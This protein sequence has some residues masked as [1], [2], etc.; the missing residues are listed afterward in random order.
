M[1]RLPSRSVPGFS[2]LAGFLWTA[3]LRLEF[4]KNLEEVF[5]VRL[6]CYVVDVLVSD[7]AFLI[8]DEKSA[9]RDSV[10][11]TIRAVGSRDFAF[12]MK[13]AQEIIRKI[14]EALSP[15]GVARDAVNRDAQD[16]GIVAFEAFEISFIGRHLCRSDRR[17]RQRVER[18]DD[19]LLPTKIRELHLLVFLKMALQLEIRGHISNFRHGEIVLLN[20]MDDAKSF[21]CFCKSDS[22][23]TSLRRLIQDCVRAARVESSGRA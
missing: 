14:A 9:F 13:V 11:L 23:V 8:H 1:E 17:P 4:A 2:P 10:R 22:K 15:G 5:V 3:Y 7:L 21:I 12:R 16:L 20:E 18:H 19:A 6:I